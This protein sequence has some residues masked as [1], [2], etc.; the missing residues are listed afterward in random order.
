VNISSSGSGGQGATGNTGA[1]GNQ[2]PTGNPGP[3]GGST[4]NTGATG[5]TGPA[6]AT[7]SGG[8]NLG[9]LIIYFSGK[10]DQVQTEIFT[11]PMPLTGSNL[12]NQSFNTPELTVGK[13]SVTFGSAASYNLRY[14]LYTDFAMLIPQLNG[15][16]LFSSVQGTGQGACVGE[17]LFTVAPSDVLQMMVLV[18]DGQQT[19]L[20]SYTTTPG[21]TP[22]APFSMVLERFS[23]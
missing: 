19:F 10:T 1:T 5:A 7:G 23:E 20:T 3:P 4:G 12:F 17:A 18:P 2:G 15:N 13:T 16:A 6:G 9:K 14:N 22:T 11:G 8:A 21:S